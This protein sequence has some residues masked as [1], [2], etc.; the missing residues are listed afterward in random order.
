MSHGLKVVEIATKAL[1][2]IGAFTVNMVAPDPDELRRTVQWMDLV[3]SNA[4]GGQRMFVLT[5]STTT[6]TLTA[7]T[8]SYTL[9]TLLGTSYP[10]EGILFAT[11]AH[12]RDSASV[13]SVLEIISREDYEDISNKTLSGVPKQIYIDRLSSATEQKVYIYPVPADSTYSLR[14]TFQSYPTDM[15]GGSAAGSGNVA[16]G[17]ADEWQLWLI[18]ALAAQIG[19]GPVRRLPVAETDRLK[20]DAGLL[21]AQLTIYANTQKTTAPKRVRAAW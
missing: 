9:S 20:N 13:D 12:L 11:A 5:P 21:L 1:E 18:T 15:L 16:H 4:G 14:L 19:D 6:S 8:S 7:A 3:V 2:K 10:D 17:F